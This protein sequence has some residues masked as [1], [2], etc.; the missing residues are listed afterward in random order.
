[1]KKYEK[2]TVGQ[3]I[4]QVEIDSNT[5]IVMNNHTSR[6]HCT[7]I[8]ELKQ[9]KEHAEQIIKSVRFRAGHGTSKYNGMGY[10]EVLI[11]TYESEVK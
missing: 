6:A 5:N 3:W 7:T 4:Q 2:P 11:D 10:V 8:Y 9:D 1:M